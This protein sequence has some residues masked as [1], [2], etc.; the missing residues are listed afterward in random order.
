MAHWMEST[1]SLFALY[2]VINEQRW[3][4]KVG[5]IFEADWWS[6]LT[7]R[8]FFQ[9]YFFPEQGAFLSNRDEGIYMQANL[10]LTRI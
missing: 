6:G 1:A 4:Y 9:K 10:E 3:N 7:C 8:L 5:N 2:Y